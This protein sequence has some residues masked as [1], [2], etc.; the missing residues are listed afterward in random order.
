MNNPINIQ[1]QTQMALKKLIMCYWLVQKH[2]EDLKS[3]KLV[4]DDDWLPLFD[5]DIKNYE[6]I[7]TQRIVDEYFDFNIRTKKKDSRKIGIK[8]MNQ[9]YILEKRNDDNE[10]VAL[11]RDMCQ[12]RIGWKRSRM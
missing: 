6:Q 1:K 4:D 8:E 11:T 2:F 3:N 5:R 9:I 10:D 12:Q 7:H